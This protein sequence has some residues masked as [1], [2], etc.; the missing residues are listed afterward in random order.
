MLLLQQGHSGTLLVKGADSNGEQLQVR[1]VF[2]DHSTAKMKA[3]EV[4][5]HKGTSTA[6]L[7]R[8]GGRIGRLV[9]CRRARCHLPR[10]KMPGFAQWLD[11]VENNGS[12]IGVKRPARVRVE[13]LVAARTPPPTRARVQFP[14]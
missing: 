8:I 2:E 3:V 5:L 14:Y 12:P 13:Q 4:V 1:I 11:K 7:T 6:G 9:L 10:P